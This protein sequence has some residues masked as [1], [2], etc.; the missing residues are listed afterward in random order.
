MLKKILT[1]NGEIYY[2][3]TKKRGL[4]NIRLSV[5]GRFRAQDFVPLRDSSQ[6]VGAENFLP[7]V[8]VS[9]PWLVSS[10]RIENFIKEK[11]DWIFK[12]IDS[13]SS[14]RKNKTDI[15]KEF[16]AHY[17]RDKSKARRLVKERL[18]LYNEYYKFDYKRI[19]IKN[20][21]GSWGSCSSLKNLNFNFRLIYLPLE[22]ADYVIIHEL[23]HLQEMNHSKRFWDLV[24]K[25]SAKHKVCRAGLRKYLIG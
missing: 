20:T 8:R 13:V 12:A 15:D 4:K 3:L 2:Q 19:F 18:S 21:K 16:G 7:L 22:L 17:K 9:A 6:S 10:S 24:V 25:Q 23:C 5:G 1:K 11:S 14:V